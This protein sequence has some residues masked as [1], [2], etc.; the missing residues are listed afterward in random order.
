MKIVIDIK[1]CRGCPHFE[2]K[3][4]CSSDGWDR[5]EDWFC[6]KEQKTI[7]KAVEWTDEKYLEIPEWCPCQIQDMIDYYKAKVMDHPLY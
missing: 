4:P 7:S 6:K 3:N 1:N 2:T 5:M